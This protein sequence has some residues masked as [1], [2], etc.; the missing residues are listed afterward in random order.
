MISGLSDVNLNFTLSHGA[1]TPYGQAPSPGPIQSGQH[2]YIAQPQPHTPYA[3]PEAPAGHLPY[4]HYGAQDHTTPYGQAPIQSA[5]GQHPS[6]PHHYVPLS[7]A[8]ALGSYAP[9]GPSDQHPV[10]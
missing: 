8:H 1:T 2:R 7:Q 5:S 9:A 6:Q 3:Q 4:D 10:V